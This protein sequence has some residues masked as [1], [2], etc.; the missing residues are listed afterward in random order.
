M[1]LSKKLLARVEVGIS[2]IGGHQDAATYDGEDRVFT[3]K[4][5]NPITR[6]GSTLY[7]DYATGKRGVQTQIE[8]ADVVHVMAGDLDLAEDEF[9]VE[10]DGQGGTVITG[11]KG[12]KLLLD[13]SKPKF[14][15]INGKVT[16]PAKLW[17]RPVKFSESPRMTLEDAGKK[18]M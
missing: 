3:F 11:Y 18:S 14:N 9:T 5:E 6:V 13:V 2:F 4:L 17:L 12:T 16:S 8:D 7:D 15:R 10:D 1:S